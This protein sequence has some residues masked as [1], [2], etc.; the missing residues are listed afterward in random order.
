V[1]ADWSK[2]PAKRW[3][4]VAHWCD[5]H[6]VAEAP[7]PAWS[8]AEF[9]YRAGTG[10]VGFDFPIGLPRAYAARA[11]ITNFINALPYLSDGFYTIAERPEQISLHRPFYPR[12]PG[13]TTQAHLL[14]GLGMWRMRDLFRECDARSG[15]A[16]LF[17][18][19]GARQPGRAAIAGWR[20]LL[21]PALLRRE[22]SIWPFEGKLD[23]LVD[24]GRTV[25]VE[26]YPAEAYAR[27]GVP[28]AFGKQDQA[29]RAAIGP[30][31]ADWADYFGIELTPDLR[32][33]ILDGF[34]SDDCGEDRFDAVTG[35]FG[36]LDVVLGNSPC[37]EPE[38]AIVREV[39]GWIIGLDH[40]ADRSAADHAEAAG[41]PGR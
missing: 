38:S 17:W 8:D 31:I 26:A 14:L 6:F 11:G 22:I 20:D 19:L 32:E 21:R 3:V 16:P 36:M 9:F 23:E 40:G 28:R 41:N 13:G 27:I 18:T 12:V 25:V 33:Q 35:L 29:R 5:G 7:R 39:E 1:H 34:G 2:D 30:V 24:A 4:A 37:P 15:A 10:L